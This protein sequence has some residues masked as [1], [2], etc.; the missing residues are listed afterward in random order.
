[1]Q[2]MAF[3]NTVLLETASMLLQSGGGG[4]GGAIVGLLFL[5][6][7]LVIGLVAF[8]IW[9]YAAYWVYKDAESQ[10]ESGVM[11]GAIVF[12]TGLLGLAVYFLAIR[13]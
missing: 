12:L 5:I 10:G 4:G 11:W 9:A 3:G 2:P 1:M 6:L 13:E 8:A 7:P